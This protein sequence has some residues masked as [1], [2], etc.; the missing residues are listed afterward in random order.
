M[1]EKLTTHVISALDE[2]APLK[3]FKIR[4]QHKFGLST[5]TKNLIRDKDQARKK[6][7]SEKSPEEK[8]IQHTIYK[9]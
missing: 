5:V 9:K 8:K 7:A 4:D 2:C 1:T 3:T 6:I